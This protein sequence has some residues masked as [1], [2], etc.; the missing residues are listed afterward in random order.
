MEITTHVLEVVVY[1]HFSYLNRSKLLWLSLTHIPSLK[2]KNAK[3]YWTTEG[4][5]QIRYYTE[6]THERSHHAAL[7]LLEDLL[8]SSV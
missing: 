6:H 2:G 7:H 5:V 3:N 4:C 1:I 8:I